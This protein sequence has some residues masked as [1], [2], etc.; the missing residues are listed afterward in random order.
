MKKT[1]LLFVVLCFC[2]AGFPQS[3]SWYTQGDFAPRLRLKY[4]VENPL[5]TDREN[6]SVIIPRDNF[7][8]PDLQE[9]WVTVV[10]PL[11]EPATE[12]SAEL[13]ERQGGHQIRGEANGHALFHQLDDLD[14]DGLWDELFFQVNLKAKEKRTIYI[15]IGENIRG[16]NPHRT[17]ANIGSYCRHLMPFWESE[18]IGWKIWFANCVDVFGKREPVLMSN[19]LYMKNLDGYGVAHENNDYGSDIQ[20]V[21]VSFGGGAVCLFEFKDQPEV[22]SRPRFTPV[23]DQKVPESLWNAGQISDTRYAYESDLQWPVKIDHPHKN[24]ELG[25]RERLLRVQTGLYGLRRAKL[26]YVESAL[27]DL[28]AKAG[29]RINGL[30]CAEKGE[31]RTTLFKRG[32]CSFLPGRKISKI[33]KTLMIAIFGKFRLLGW[34]WWLKK[35]TIRNTSLLKNLA[36]TIPFGSSPTKT[37]ATKYMLVAGWAEGAVY[38]SKETF[39]AYVEK[40]AREFNA[41]VGVSFRTN[42]DE[43]C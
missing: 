38:N 35:L 32:V 36:E 21:D 12:P 5:D 29:R 3:G 23:H 7:P 26:L 9:M 40:C 25:Y 34:A 1:C 42:R 19:Q 31:R 16:W 4:T 39:N 13:L 10:D 2:M 22:I 6:S 11:L 14:K 30:R 15:Y 18:N 43:A 41:P 20:S 17:H 33:R 8:M 27:H 28:C 24:D 37:T